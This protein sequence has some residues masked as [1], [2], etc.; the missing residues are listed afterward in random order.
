LDRARPLVGQQDSNFTEVAALALESNHCF[1]V[2]GQYLN[3]SMLNEVHFGSYLVHFNHKIV[4][5]ADLRSQGARH[6]QDK[7]RVS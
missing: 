2:G 3:Y 6:S 4:L 1:V 7:G 5:E